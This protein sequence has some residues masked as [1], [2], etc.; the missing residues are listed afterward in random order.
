MKLIVTAFVDD[1][2]EISATVSIKSSASLKTKFSRCMNT[3]GKKLVDLGVI[4]KDAMF[5]YEL[6]NVWRNGY[7]G[8]A[9]FTEPFINVCIQEENGAYLAQ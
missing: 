3:I 5:S 9:W 4:E 2:R 1:E 8:A 7:C 6:P